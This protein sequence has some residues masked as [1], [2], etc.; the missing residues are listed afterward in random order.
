[1]CTKPDRERRN[2]IPALAG[3]EQGG[4]S[5]PQKETSVVT[6]VI[7]AYLAKRLPPN[8]T[9][10]F[11][12]A[13]LAAAALMVECARI[14]GAFTEGER[15]AICRA[16]MEELVLDLETAE[17]LV[18]V[19]ERRED[20]VWHDWLFTETIKKNFDEYDRLAV[21]R[22]LW[23]VALADGTVHP[24]EESLIARI[25]KELDVT[26]E[27]VDRRLTIALRRHPGLTSAIL[28]EAAGTSP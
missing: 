25:A 8:P 9:W 18:A 2:A 28:D 20:A 21:V 5:S 16:V 3:A 23:E 24:F 22:R 19:A 17:C 11:G 14:D 1:M 26:R 4:G 27:A 15:D 7:R 12:L 13:E 6:G 10:P